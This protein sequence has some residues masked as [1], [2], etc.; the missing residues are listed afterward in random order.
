MGFLPHRNNLV[1]TNN[2]SLTRRVILTNSQKRS[3]TRMIHLLLITST[4]FASQDSDLSPERTWRTPDQ[5]ATHL[6]SLDS[7]ESVTISTIGLSTNGSPIQCIQIARNGTIPVDHRSAIL[8]VAGIDGGH[9]LGSEVAVDL[10]DYLLSKET[11]ST[12][13]LLETHALYIIPQ[14]NPD[15][16]QYYF[17]SVQDDEQKN[18]RP[19]DDDH[20][21][22][23]DED[24]GDD[25]NGD[26]YI[27]MMRV[28]NVEKATHLADPDEPRLHIKP[29]ALKDQSAT[30]V[31]YKE[32]IDNDNDGKY[33]EDEIG[34]VNLNK[35]FMHGYQIHGDG[36]GPWQL[37]EHESK[38]LADFVLQHQEIAAIVVYGH[39]DTLSK[40]FTE[41]GKDKAG[42]PKKL[43]AGDVDIYKEVS[44]RFIELTS[45]K[46][47]TQPNWDGS[48]VA[49]AYTQYGVPAFSTPL[50]S[51]PD[52]VENEEGKNDPKEDGAMP[53]STN[54]DSPRGEGRGRGGFDREAIRA[55]FDAN[56]DGELSDDERSA[57]R[58]SMRERFGGLKGS[59]RGKGGGES[60][61]ANDEPS[62]SYEGELVTPSGIGDISQ[63]TLDELLQAAEAAG[64]P[65]TDEMMEEITPEQV[66]QY[67]KMS[68]IQIRRVKKSAA[69]K[70]SSSDEIA[71]LAYSDDIRGGEGFV[72]WTAFEHPQLGTVEIGG[73]IPYFKTVPPIG[74]IDE[75]T[76]TQADFLVDLASKLPEVHLETPSIKKLGNGLWEVKVAVR[77]DG[78]F[79]TGTAMAKKNKRARPYVVRL[80]VPNE[81]IISGRKVQRIWSL[82]GG[83]TRQWFTWIIQGKTNEHVNIILFSEKFGGETISVS[84]QNTTGGDV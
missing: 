23:L 17:S 27:T 62:G 4:L 53:D 48:F 49:W 13:D 75:I 39:H 68:G 18:R 51:R 41:N 82:A 50:W 36:A 11:E 1:P 5:I 58:E 61:R 42:A 45:L 69:S 26:G 38:A 84:L 30:F 31:L 63:E 28:P 21:G 56:G 22:L 46:N 73:W 19:T 59:G 70:G 29:N 24:G 66:E 60:A 9:I 54:E 40:P 78:W 77:N 8:V 14:V 65:V 71:W 83:G 25:L 43:D 15:V 72:E 7:N 52:P 6:E 76:T 74:A 10:C 55:E 2:T 37:S 16:A 12:T 33:N 47:T 64:F 79:P 3:P 34:G 20:D 35:N 80:D 57:I 81:T 32:G 44:N 67:A